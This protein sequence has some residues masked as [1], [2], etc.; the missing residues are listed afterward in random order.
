[1]SAAGSRWDSNDA[2]FLREIMEAFADPEVN[3]ITCMC[4]AQS[5]KTLTQLVLL[6]YIISEDPGSILWVAAN[7]DE[8]RKISKSRIFP[9]LEGCPPVAKKIPNDRSLNTMLQVYFPG[10]MLAIASAKNENALRSTPYRYI[11]LDEVSSYPAG[12]VQVASSRTESFPNYKKIVIS[13]AGEEHDQIHLAYLAGDQR[14]YHVK[15]EGCGGHHSLEWG[16]NKHPGGMRW[17]SDD[18]T[19]PNGE[20]D[21]TVLSPTIRY[22]CPICGHKTYSTVRERKAFSRNGKWV[23]TNPKAPKNI[24]SYHWNKILPW[25]TKWD[26]AVIEYLNS[27]RALK[28]GHHEALKKWYNETL[29]K[30]FE[31]RLKYADEEE[32]Q[33]MLFFLN[34]QLICKTER[35][36]CDKSLKAEKIKE[37]NSLCKKTGDN[38]WTETKNGKS[39][40]IIIKDEEWSFNITITLKE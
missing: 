11:F 6:A 28:Y 4:S 26:K 23:P 8:A 30:P 33:T 18:T 34:E 19:K 27:V 21:F 29:G 24:R 39:Y 9:I 17:D 14:E 36:V 37:L 3:E 10:G 38:E 16:D 1:M 25:W 15:C 12:A 7:E 22:E 35:M 20:Y 13:T 32:T 31:D 2:A 5:G 40:L